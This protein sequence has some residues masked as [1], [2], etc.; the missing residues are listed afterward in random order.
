MYTKIAI[1]ISTIIFFYINTVNG[2]KNPHLTEMT[3]YEIFELKDR[4][5]KSTKL[6][7]KFD[8]ISIVSQLNFEDFTYNNIAK[9]TD[10][11][12]YEIAWYGGK[13]VFISCFI[14]KPQSMYLIY[15][16]KIDYFQNIHVISLFK[17]SIEDLS[18]KTRN[19]YYGFIIDDK[20]SN[21]AIFI[22]FVFN[23]YY[24]N[25]LKSVERISFLSTSL[26]TENQLFLV[27]GNVHYKTR[28][29]RDTSGFYICEAVEKVN[30]Q[31]DKD[32]KIKNLI[33][34]TDDISNCRYIYRAYENMHAKLF[35]IW[36]SESANYYPCFLL[37]SD[38]TANRIWFNKIS[39]SENKKKVLLDTVIRGEL[40]CID[41]SPQKNRYKD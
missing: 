21:F 8:S 39:G 12:I 18:N 1:I 4:A 10:N 13:I 19:G 34:L 7:Y 20:N 5:I 37:E 32:E 22:G 15:T 11:L 30:Y 38:T 36:A 14:Q 26:I 41:L 3:L 2:Q 6:T 31:V 16:M 9:K 27:R 35:P 40:E 25:T 29:I 17:S 24:K 28:P 23:A 33:N